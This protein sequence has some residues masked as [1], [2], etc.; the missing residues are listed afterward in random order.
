M[1][2]ALAKAGIT[3]QTQAL[4]LGAWV[5]NVLAYQSVSDPGSTAESTMAFSISTKGFA[6]G[7]STDVAKAS[8]QEYQEATDPASQADALDKFQNWVGAELPVIPTVSVRPW[9]VRSSRVG[10]YEGLGQITQQALA[11]EELWIG[12]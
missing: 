1:Q 4:D 5:D 7:W 2:A 8:L 6:G 12:K 10:G 3:L 11:F 9:L